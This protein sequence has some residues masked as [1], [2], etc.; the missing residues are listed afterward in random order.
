M[1]EYR[2]QE[3][4]LMHWNL[5]I[6]IFYTIYIYMHAYINN[7]EKYITYIRQRKKWERFINLDK[8]L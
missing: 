2:Q 7:R 5:H 3:G 4:F 6:V 8:K 1:K